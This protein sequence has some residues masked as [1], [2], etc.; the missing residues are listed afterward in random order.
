VAS[1]KQEGEPG[2]LGIELPAANLGRRLWSLVG[3]RTPLACEFEI[4]SKCVFHCPHCYLGQL[5]YARSEGLPPDMVSGLLRQMADAGTFWVEF[6]GGEPFLRS[7][8]FEQLA[9]ARRLGMVPTVFSNAYL[10]TKEVVQRL[11]DV[12]PHRVEVSMYACSSDAYVRFTGVEDSFSRVVSA[13]DLLIA[14]DIPIRLKTA[15]TSVNYD[16]MAGID[17]FARSRGLKLQIQAEILPPVDGTRLTEGVRLDPER[18]AYVESQ[19]RQFQLPQMSEASGGHSRCQAGRGMFYVDCDG[20]LSPCVVYRHVSAS[21]ASGC[22]QH[23]WRRLGEQLS[24]DHAIPSTCEQCEFRNG[25][26]ICPGWA[27]L[28][29]GNEQAIVSYACAL[30]K[31]RV[32]MR[33]P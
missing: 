1:H 28:E 2:R 23:A 31:A 15:I 26:W 33:N 21:A 10:I 25:C 8:I 13:V 9:L 5:R 6:T 12:R 11:K 32:M 20:N 22:F 3:D 27:Y 7:D 14:S 4:T 19:F 18:V 16:Q 30:T 24:N 17:A 29:C